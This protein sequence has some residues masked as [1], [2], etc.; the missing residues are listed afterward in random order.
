[1]LEA[2]D[3]AE[4]MQNLLPAENHWQPVRL[5]GGRDGV[6]QVPVSFKGNLVE[7]AEGSDRDDDRARGQLLLVRQIELVGANLRLTQQ[8]RRLAEISCEPG[9][10]LEVGRLRVRRQVSH[11]HVL[12]HPL[13]KGCHGG[14]PLRDRVRCT[15]HPMLA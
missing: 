9:D 4:E 5:S 2:F 8:L 1:M 11:L 3:R 12:D 14:S 15:R 10:L 7:K 6:F 13:P